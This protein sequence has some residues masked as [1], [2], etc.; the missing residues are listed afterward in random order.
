MRSATSF[1]LL[2]RIHI[3]DN[4]VIR[5]MLF[6]TP[7]FYIFG[8]V[9][10][11][12]SIASTKNLQDDTVLIQNEFVTCYS[13]RLRVHSYYFPVGDKTIRYEDIQSCELLRHEQLNF[14]QMKCWGM[15]FSPIWWPLDWLRQWREYYLI[16]EANQWPKI[17]ITMNDRDIV[18]VYGLIKQKM[19]AKLN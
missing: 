14:F 12:A 13:D 4:S 9:F 18:D 6:T 16:I 7:S 5:L 3:V 11:V 19:A 1:F 15:A 17:G 10:F 2:A 8:L